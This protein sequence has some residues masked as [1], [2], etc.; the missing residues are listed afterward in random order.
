MKYSIAIIGK[1]EEIL[2][3][4]GIGIE[5]I[6]VDSGKDAEKILM[7]LRK[8]KENKFAIIFL[9]E[10]IFQDISEEAMEKITEEALPALVPIPG[11][12]GSTGFG[13]LRMRKFVEQAVGSDI[14]AD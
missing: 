8:E 4:K 9:P 11:L 6:F 3:F 7:D 14:F 1:K 5:T 2:A 10:D 12:Q 13:D